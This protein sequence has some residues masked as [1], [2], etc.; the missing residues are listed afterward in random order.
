MDG[1][2]IERRIRLANS[3][4]ARQRHVG[5]AVSTAAAEEAEAPE[6]SG[7]VHEAYRSKPETVAALRR[8]ICDCRRLPDGEPVHR[9]GCPAVAELRKRPAAVWFQEVE[10]DPAGD[11]VRA[12][13]KPDEY[14]D[15]RGVIRKIQ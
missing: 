10:A 7:A 2:E 12:L 1:R 3:I 5:G 14:L 8:P 13:L 15:E 4:F 6:A 11:A 9:P